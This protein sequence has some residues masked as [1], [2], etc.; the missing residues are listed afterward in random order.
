VG[1]SLLGAVVVSSAVA[2]HS[3]SVSRD[4]PSTPSQ[5]VVL[6]DPTLSRALGAMIS[7]PGEVDWYRMDLL[8]GD[9]IVL[10]M[11][12]PDATGRLAAT[13]LLVGPGLPDAAGVGDW[14]ASLATEAGVPGAIQFT[15]DP[16][17]AR[18]V[19]AGLGFL[20]YGTLRMEAPTD[21]SYW[22]AVY[23][24]DPMGT[25]KYVLAPGVREEFGA[26]AVGGMADLVGFFLEPWP[27]TAAAPP[28]S[29]APSSASPGI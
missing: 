7:R 20:Q 24:V 27:P 1:L 15:P 10:G 25:G 9:P 17:P 26:D 18:E 28:S 12:A 8:A 3:P 13:F 4:E 29:P 22:V 21:G 2:A 23:A 19:H 16:D 14:A 11:T 6:D 5:A